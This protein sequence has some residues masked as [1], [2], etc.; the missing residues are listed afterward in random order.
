[1]GMLHIYKGFIWSHIMR[2]LSCLLVSFLPVCFLTS[3]SSSLDQNSLRATNDTPLPAVVEENIIPYE[4][5]LPKYVIVVDI[6][7][8]WGFGANYYNSGGCTTLSGGSCLGNQYFTINPLGYQGS[9][10]RS[11]LI[12]A[13]SKV[14]NFSIADPAVVKKKSDGTYSV[15]LNRGEVGPFVIRGSVTEVNETNEKIDQGGFS[16]WPVGLAMGI[17]GAATGKPGIFWPGAALAGINPGYESETT[18]RTGL[19]GLDMQV[20][21]GRTMRLI[22]A[23]DVKGT[24]K[25]ASASSGFTLLWTKNT[26]SEFAQSALGQAMR[27]A[28][29]DATSKT[30]ESLTENQK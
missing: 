28:I 2:S 18:E 6:A 17:A 22:D 27:V 19:I 14:G 15:K 12:S 29:R 16:L 26:D 3:C 9:A 5:S 1:M 7:P 8:D 11:Q 21:D 4:Q 10:L 23:F 24:F 13:L 25:S 20:Y 30:Y